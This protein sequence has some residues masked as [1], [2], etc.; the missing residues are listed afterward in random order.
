MEEESSRMKAIQ[1]WRGLSDQERT[2]IANEYNRGSTPLSGR[3]VENVCDK[4][5][6]Q[7]NPHPDS[8]LDS[9]H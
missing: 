3:E 6:S 5:L 2:H 8:P 7:Q 4:A 9:N 1:W